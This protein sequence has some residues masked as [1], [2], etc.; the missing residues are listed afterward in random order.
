MSS[1]YEPN[2]SIK[3]ATL[4][5]KLQCLTLLPILPWTLFQVLLTRAVW[6]NNG[7]SLKADLICTFLR[8][9]QPF[10]PLSILRDVTKDSEP[11]FAKSQRFASNRTELYEKVSGKEFSGRWICKG[12]PGKPKAASNVDLVLYYLHGGAYQVG[13]PASALAPFL[14]IA[15]LANKKGISIAVFAL[16]YSLTPEAQFPT[17]VIQAKAAYRYLLEDQKIDAA[18]IA[19]IGDSAGAHLILSLL[20]VLADEKSLPKPGAGVFLIAPWI[21]LRCTRDGSWVRNRDSDYLLRNWIIR[22][23]LQVMP[24]QLDSTVPHI[25]NFALPR[26]DKQSWAQILPAKVW[27][28]I[29]SKDV[30]LDDAIAFVDRVKGDGVNVEF[31]IDN[32]KV[33]DWHIVEDLLD[34]DQYF[35]TVGEVPQGLMKGA[36]NMAEVIIS[37]LS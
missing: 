36:K 20:S 5:D 17:Q 13:H 32:G 21:D 33:H 6:T 24:R 2:P 14:H 8:L 18:K 9:A 16:D 1:S 11:K 34:A 3:S 25:I 23:G 35:A 26:P 4:M 30:L 12:C 28:G 27:V 7:L 22:A 10:L 19:P 29:G 31:Q 37:S 15:E